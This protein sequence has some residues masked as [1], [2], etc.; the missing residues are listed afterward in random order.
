MPNSQWLQEVANNMANDLFTNRPGG[1]DYTLNF[2][3]RHAH[4]AGTAQLACPFFTDAEPIRILKRAGYQRILLLVRLCESTSPAALREA[5]AFT[6]VNIRY[7]TSRKFHA[8]FYILGD[9]ALIG[10]AN[11]TISGMKTNRELSI[12]IDASDP[13]FDD[14][15]AY[16][17]ELWSAPPAALLTNDVLDAFDDWHQRTTIPA[18]QPMTGVPAAE[19]VN[20]HVDS[21][22]ASSERVYLETFRAAYVETLIPAYQVVREV[23]REQNARHPAFHNFSEAYEID[24]FLFWARSFTTDEDLDQN[25]VRPDED[26]RANVRHHVTDWLQ[27]QNPQIEEDR[28]L[29][30]RQLQALFGDEQRLMTVEM[31]ALTDMLRGCAAFEEILRFT[32][33]GLD[34]HLAAFMRDNDIEAVRVTLRHLAFGDED[35]AKR[36]YDC[37]YV[38]KYKIAHWGRNCTLELF[39]WVN[40]EEVPP[41]NGRIVN[42]LRYL[43]FNVKV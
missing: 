23:Y 6:G 40:R 5:R 29:R 17:E 24:R 38:P 28:P 21:W 31:G 22:K 3:W 30:I 20:I 7:Y 35:F 18:P 36:T 39:G 16:F 25:P 26:L 15:P 2:F 41:F 37:I 9:R 43:G 33:G 10:S 8:K 27:K 12:M 4:G 32:Q 1:G 42:A 11:L 34:A 13:R 19:P 14:V